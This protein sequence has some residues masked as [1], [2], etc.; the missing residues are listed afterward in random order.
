MS[1]N[2]VVENVVD[3]RTLV[4][5]FIPYGLQSV[6]LSIL[7]YRDAKEPMQYDEER[8]LVL[9]AM[10]DP[11]TDADGM[12]SYAIL[13][14]D[15]T[16]VVGDALQ[17]VIH[18][19]HDCEFD[20]TTLMAM[21]NEGGRF[22]NLNKVMTGMVSR[23]VSDATLET[24]VPEAAKYV[25]KLHLEKLKQGAFTEDLHR[26]HLLKGKEKR[27]P[28]RVIQHVLHS[29]KT[30]KLERERAQFAENARHWHHGGRGK[31]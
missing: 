19:P 24:Y 15:A 10:L 4:V 11:V 5:R 8:F 9:S 25:G 17:S 18:V 27:I 29:K 26:A 21:C 31:K 16:A 7:Q 23:K 2:A 1:I 6:R 12:R 22:L 3:H 13:H 20:E 30:S 28:E 14:V